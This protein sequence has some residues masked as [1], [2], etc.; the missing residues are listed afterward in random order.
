MDGHAVAL[1][2]L[3]HLDGQI[4]VAALGQHGDCDVLVAAG[5]A[6]A[7]LLTLRCLPALRIF[8]ST[9]IQPRRIAGVAKEP[10]SAPATKGVTIGTPVQWRYVEGASAV[11]QGPRRTTKCAA[12]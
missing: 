11:L 5:L 7:L 8:T 1:S 9:S 2:A 10:R 6:A 3:E 4:E 12:P